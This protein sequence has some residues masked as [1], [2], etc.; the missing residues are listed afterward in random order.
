MKE[1]NFRIIELPTH[2]VMLTRDFNSD[3]EEDNA[4]PTIVVAF[5]IEGLKISL[6]MAYESE[7]KRNEM[8]LSF[9]DESAQKIVDDILTRFKD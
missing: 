5:F 2:Q 7:T 8:F 6:E 9:S 1:V 4:K 3:N